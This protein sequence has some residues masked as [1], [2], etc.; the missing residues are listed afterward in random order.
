MM[1]LDE[2]I[3]HAQDRALK[4]D[5]CAD[6]HR[7][8]ACWLTEL[9]VL[10]E[11]YGLIPDRVLKEPLS[12]DDLEALEKSTK[13]RFEP[14]N[15]V[16]YGQDMSVWQGVDHTLVFEVDKHM[17]ERGVWLIAPGYGGNPYGNGRILVYYNQNILR[18][19]KTG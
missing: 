2:A 11:K 7:Q 15:E 4:R 8:L 14:N 10:R 13:I 1:T 5:K 17:E 6:E 19:E 3:L 9:K 18:R 16:V 12:C